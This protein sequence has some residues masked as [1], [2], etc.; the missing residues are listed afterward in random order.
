MK[1]LDKA[2]EWL[3]RNERQIKAGFFSVY[4]V[5]SVVNYWK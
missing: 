1:N 2:N 4:S 3:Q 5:C